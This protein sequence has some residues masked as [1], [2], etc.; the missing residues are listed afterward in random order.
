MRKENVV[1]PVKR[2]TDWN[3]GFA[4]ARYAGSHYF[5]RVTPGSAALHPGLY[6][7]ACSAGSLCASAKIVVGRAILCEVFNEPLDRFR[8]RREVKLFDFERRQ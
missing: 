2:A 7:F 4:V 8:R 1:E 5:C 6:A 3:S